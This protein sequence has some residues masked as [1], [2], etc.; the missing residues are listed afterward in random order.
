MVEARQSFAVYVVDDDASIRDSLA[1]LLGLRGYR[2]ALFASAEDFLAAFRPDWRGCLLTDLRLPGMSGLDLQRE[3]R[4][5]GAAMP[6]VIITGH[7]DIAAARAAFKADAVDFIEK[8]FDD[9]GPIVAIEAAFRREV[10]RV[11]GDEERERRGHTWASLTERERTVASLVIEGLHNR[12]I[13]LQLGISPRTVEVHKSRLME[14][15][16]ARNLAELIRLAR[17]KGA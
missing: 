10:A 4:Q 8:P 16:G 5:R 13:A 3:L 9:D 2:A 14:K 7:G 6:V 15:L 17:E 1:L 12:D 11:S